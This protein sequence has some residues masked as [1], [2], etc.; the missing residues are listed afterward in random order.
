MRSGWP[1][2]IA[3]ANVNLI[4]ASPELLAALKALCPQDH[5]DTCFGMN[6]RVGSADREAKCTC[7]AALARAAIAKAEG[8]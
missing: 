5:L 8:M 4:A 7:G 2:K 1:Q 6:Y 3:R